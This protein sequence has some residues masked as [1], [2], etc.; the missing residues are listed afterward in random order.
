MS[1]SLDAIPCDIQQATFHRCHC[2]C[3]PIFYRPNSKVELMFDFPIIC[4]KCG[5]ALVG[6]MAR[7]GGGAGNKLHGEGVSSAPRRE[8]EKHYCCQG[9]VEHNCGNTELGDDRK[10]GGCNYRNGPACV[11]GIILFCASFTTQHCMRY[12]LQMY[13][14][15]VF[16]FVIQTLIFLLLT[17]NLLVNDLF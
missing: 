6:W 11:C 10:H 15:N 1:Q 3:I 7:E 12:N 5:W 16:F 17:L 14:K 13:C 8:I 4:T 9:I 2:C